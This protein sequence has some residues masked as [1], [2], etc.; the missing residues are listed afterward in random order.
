MTVWAN[1]QNGVVFE[2]INVSP[3]GRYPT[4]MV[5][6]D[7]TAT[8]GVAQGWIY[9][10]GLVFV[11][12]AGISVA[13]ALAS[14]SGFLEGIEGRGVQFQ[15][16]SAA[17]PSYYDTATTGICKLT[18]AFVAAQSGLW[19]EGTPIKALDNTYVSFTSADVQALA[20]KALAYVSACGLHAQ[21][22]AGLIQTV[23]GTDLSTGWPS[24]N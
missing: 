4:S 5:W 2:L 11:P 14:L 22:L 24:N 17:A 8:A 1:V 15:A 12:P 9:L 10:G 13:K 19:I 18:A 23:P 3:V 20:T 6:V 7:C 21:Y 16:S